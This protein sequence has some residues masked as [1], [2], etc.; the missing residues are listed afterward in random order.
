VDPS[1]D[2]GERRVFEAAQARGGSEQVPQPFGLGLVL[3]PLD[4]RQRCPAVLGSREVVPK[5][6]LVG[7][8]VFGH[9]R[10]EPLAQRAR[11][12]RSREFHRP[13]SSARGQ[14]W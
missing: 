6:L 2:L 1:H 5:G 3:Q 10:F 8:D 14:S 4:Q 13:L 9:E 11:A 12:F 7:L